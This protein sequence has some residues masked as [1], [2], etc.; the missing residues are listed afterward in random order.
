MQTL[1]EIV[2]WFIYRVSNAYFRIAGKLMRRDRLLLG[3]ER[4]F[5]ALLESAPDAIVIADWHGHIAI[6]NEETEKLFGYERRELIGRNIE[7]L[8]PSGLRGR[9]RQHLK[10][11]M[12]EPRR[13]PMGAGLSLMARRR[14][15]TEFPVEISLGPLGTDEGMLVSAVIRDV[16]ERKKDESRLRY[17]AD[18][19]A[20]TGLLNRR[21][22]EEELG[23]EIARS[24]RYRLPGTM[25]LID[26]DGLKDVNDTLGHA[27]GDELIRSVAELISSR[28]RET[29]L[30]ARLGGD[31][32]GVLMPNTAA[33]DARTVAEELLTTVRNHG[34]VLGAHRL[35]PS[36]C[37]GVATFEHG[38][39]DSGD[40]MVA[41]DLALY[42]AKQLG[43]GRVAVHEPAPGEFAE[44][45]E[46]VTWSKRIRRALD[47]RLLIPYR[48]PIMDLESRSVSQYELL[49]R[50]LDEQGRV[51]A[52][53]AFLPTAE[54]T[55]MVREL[56][57]M[58]ASAAIDLIRRSQSLGKPVSYE[59]NL[60][61]RSLADPEL[62]TLLSS[63]ISEAGIDPS[64][65][66]F[67]IT[68]TAAIA[69]MEQARGF[70]NRLRH[71]GCRFALD[72]FG[73]GF[74]SFY[75]L[76]HIPLDAL[77]IDGDFVRNLRR[78]ATDQ[79]VVRH[80][81][82]IANALD[83]LTIA[84]F[85]EDEETLEM[86]AEFG[87]DA[88]QGFHIGRPEPVEPFDTILLPPATGQEA[89]SSPTA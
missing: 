19:D 84:E 52:P 28:M 79:L 11:Y 86:L 82:E 36:A 66:V 7:E 20:L 22:F 23:K 63:R 44:W 56:D 26:I 57:R 13:R 8:M 59:V 24:G 48:Q 50:M 3:S 70:A 55:G 14:D 40:V 10:N 58:M 25:L 42:E 62:A 30:V 4:K 15:G 65:L 27:Q 2:R 71:L 37:A 43:Q 12:R 61:A 32:F 47:E 5:R 51:V 80:I 89:G 33:A 6:V 1:G 67:E 49:A 72:D 88:V 64:L 9:H 53:G 17:L 76:K 39:A 81:A 78:N 46:R 16:T 69:N 68:E 54:R 83:L 29:D 77:K 34:I 60:S 18:H 73:A 38:K 21:S 87:V 41:A 45:E 35:R 31:E 74:A 75:Y 85:V